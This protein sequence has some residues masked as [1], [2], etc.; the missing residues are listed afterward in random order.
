MQS[1]N[2]NLVLE[3]RQAADFIT[4][5]ATNQ[6]YRLAHRVPLMDRLAPLHKQTI[7]VYIVVIQVS[8]VLVQAVLTYP[9]E[10]RE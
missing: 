5:K 1:Q 10:M 3:H 9:S 7:P 6:V 8:K 4:V 2:P